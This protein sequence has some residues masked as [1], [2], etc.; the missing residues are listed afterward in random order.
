MNDQVNLESGRRSSALKELKRP[1][2]HRK[3]GWT[4]SLPENRRLPS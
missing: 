3:M 2:T 1:T 4:W